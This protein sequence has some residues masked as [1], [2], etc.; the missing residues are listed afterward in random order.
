M[1]ADSHGKDKRF[2]LAEVEGAFTFEEGFSRPNWHLISKEI[3]KAESLDERAAWDEAVR[4]WMVQ[5]QADL[6]GPR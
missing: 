6:G 2:D 4:Q 3:E 1:E 5:L